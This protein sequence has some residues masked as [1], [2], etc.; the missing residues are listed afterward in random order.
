MLQFCFVYC[1]KSRF[2]VPTP[3]TSPSGLCE[4]DVAQARARESVA[5]ADEQAVVEESVID[6]PATI[7][8]SN[9]TKK[10]RVSAPCDEKLTDVANEMAEALGQKNRAETS[11][12]RQEQLTTMGLARFCAED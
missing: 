1:I 8:K 3:V 7:K 4:L 5:A 9:R 2:Y 6:V 12:A 10:A 11:S